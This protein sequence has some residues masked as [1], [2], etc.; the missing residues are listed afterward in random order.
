[1]EKLEKQIEEMTKE[2]LK[3]YIQSLNEKID[4]ANSDI[5]KYNK[6]ISNIKKM[7]KDFEKD[8]RLANS[9]LKVLEL[10]ELINT[11]TSN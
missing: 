8:L 2:E 11:S 10:E 6:R 9:V 3:N 1:M 7:I 5:Q 4:T